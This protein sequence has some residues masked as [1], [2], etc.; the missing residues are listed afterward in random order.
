MG[1]KVLDKVEWPYNSTTTTVPYEL[2]VYNKITEIIGEERESG[3]MHR[4]HKFNY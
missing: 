3:T 1:L 2:E 4:N